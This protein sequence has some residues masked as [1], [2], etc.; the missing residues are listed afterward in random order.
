MKYKGSTTILTRNK[1]IAA[2]IK[3]IL[4]NIALF[5]V[6]FSICSLID[7][8][9]INLE[10]FLTHQFI[11]I[12]TIITV[13]V[14]IVV[15]IYQNA[16]KNLGDEIANRYL[17]SR[18]YN[19]F[20]LTTFIYIFILLLLMLI[21]THNHDKIRTVL[22]LSSFLLLLNWV[23]CF[24]CY[25]RSILETPVESVLHD[26][27]SKISFLHT[28]NCSPL[29]TSLEK[30]HP[31]TDL[32]LQLFD[33]H[34]RTLRVLI[35]SF[36]Q[37]KEVKPIISAGKL[38]KESL[39]K[40]I[41]ENSIK[42]LNIELLLVFP[43]YLLKKAKLMQIS[44]LYVLLNDDYRDIFKTFYHKPMNRTD[45]INALNVINKE[46]KSLILVHSEDFDYDSVL[47]SILPNILYDW[48]QFQE[49]FQRDYI[50]L[51]IKKIMDNTCNV[52]DN[53]LIE[54]ASQKNGVVDP[55]GSF[56]GSYEQLLRIVIEILHKLENSSDIPEN[57]VTNIEIWFLEYLTE[58]IFKRYLDPTKSPLVR[59]YDTSRTIENIVMFCEKIFDYKKSDLTNAVLVSISKLLNSIP[60]ESLLKDDVVK[61][62]KFPCKTQDISTIE[63]FKQSLQK[64]QHI[65]QTPNP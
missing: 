17:K 30:S 41:S 56:L 2:C 58:E 6:L 40:Y 63:M 53:I 52:L 3:I 12:T 16:Y 25:W 42:S 43:F 37:S 54:E 34:Y 44:S 49:N 47:L 23:T 33:E 8:R 61:F 28:Q 31:Y 39:I 14:A 29:P 64:F 35:D 36:Y 5:L 32:K 27:I 18:I 22:S 45:S 1:S 21:S 62:E 13:Y 57:D 20:V 51:A 15:V 7:F 24:S 10:S 26:I 48:F 59:H 55:N 60:I 50:C 46:Y 65:E 11:L 4:I 9:S 19:A 38:Y